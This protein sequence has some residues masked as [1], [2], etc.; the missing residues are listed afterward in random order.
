MNFLTK[1]G[2]AITGLFAFS[3]VIC[4]ASISQAATIEQSSLQIHTGFG[5]ITILSAFGTMALMAYK[6]KKPII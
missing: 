3:T 2:I 5:I 4:G 1:L 6:T